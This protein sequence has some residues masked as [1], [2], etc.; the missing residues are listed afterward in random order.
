MSNETYYYYCNSETKTKRPC[1][2]PVP[3]RGDKCH[4]HR[5][6][7]SPGGGGGGGG[8]LSIPHVLG[9]INATVSVLLT[10][11]GATELPEWIVELAGI[12]IR[13]FN[14]ICEDDVIIPNASMKYIDEKT[15]SSLEGLDLVSVNDEYSIQI[16]NCN[17]DDF[18]K[19]IMTC[20]RLV[21]NKRHLYETSEPKMDD[22]ELLKHETFKTKD[23]LPTPQASYD[24]LRNMQKGEA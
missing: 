12:F 10:M 20:Q 5:P 2:N 11:K 14:I 1:R 8:G 6:V 18:E 4:L 17:P 19:L 13:Q 16:K 15:I 21:L 22:P 24:M 7:I 3:F 23:F 9:L